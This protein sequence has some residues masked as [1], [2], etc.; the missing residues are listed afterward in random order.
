M[1]SSPIRSVV[2]QI[3]DAKHREIEAAR[4]QV[5]EADLERRLSQAPVVRDFRAALQ[6]PGGIQAIAEVKKASPSA[7]VMR[8]DFDPVAV[9]RN[10]AQ[11]GAA[12]ISVLTDEPFF[13]GR[14]SYLSAIRAAVTP[15]LLRKDFLLEPYQLL[16]ARAAGADA[17]LL[18]AEILDDAQLARLLGGAHVL[19]M[20]A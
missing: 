6:R 16:E 4:V 12:A 5:S 14:L 19:G 7:G 18:I 9:A 15:P 8:A 10:Y 2:D 13:Q 11:H 17:V 3:G 20:Q 1:P